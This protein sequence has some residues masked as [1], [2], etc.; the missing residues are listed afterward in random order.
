MAPTIL[1]FAGAFAD[2]KCFDTICEQF[3]KAG[4]PTAYAYVPSL[5]ASDP[6]SVTT[7]HDANF[8]RSK[9]LLSLLEEGKDVVVFVHSYGGIVGRRS[10]RGRLR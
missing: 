5:D 3:H 10:G 6:A 8:A 9:Y 2:P 7:A 1:F 4:Y